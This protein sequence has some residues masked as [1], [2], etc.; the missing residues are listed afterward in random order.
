MAKLPRILRRLA[1]STRNALELAKVGRLGPTYGAPYEIVDQGPHHRL[2]R[3]ATCQDEAGPPVLLVPPLM[4]TSEVYD[5]DQ[6]VS[7][8]AALGRAGLV[9]FVVDFGA[10]ERE[11]GG[12]ERTLDDHVRAVVRSVARVRAITGRD[13][14]L[15][16]YSQG[17]MF[18][19]QAAAYLRSEGIKSLVTFGSPVDIH[20]NVPAVHAEVAGKI[21]RFVEPA[22]TAVV[23]Q[24]EALPGALT[25][26]GFKLLSTR[27]EIEQR[28]EF[29]QKLHDRRALVRRE[30]RRRFLGGEGFVAWPG[31]ALRTFVDE[32]IVHN[33]MLS[34]GF[35]ID[36]RTVTLADI[37]CPI[38]AFM[39]SS[40]ELAR[41]AAVRAITRAAPEAQVSFATVK[42]GHFGIVVGS[43]AS[44]VTWPTVAAWCLHH[45][46]RGPLPELLRS[47]EHAARSDDHDDEPEGAGFDVDVNVELFVDAI[48]DSVKAAWQRLGDVTA[49]AGDALDGVRFQEPR[50]R[51]LSRM[52]P[53]TLVNAGKW[54][55]TRAREAPEA[56][57]FLWQGRA[58]TNR[59]ADQ[60]V[61]NVVRGLWASRVEPRERVGVIMGSRP[62]F[63]T[64]VTALVRLGAV[65]VIA[66][67]DASAAS[68]AR[69]F[70]LE[71]IRVV[72]CDPA[73]AASVRSWFDGE[74]LVL[75]GGGGARDLGPGLVDLEAI[76]PSLVELP[77]ELVLDGGCARDLGLVLLRPSETGELR[78]APVTHHRWA[79]SALGAAAACTLTPDD[80]V[81]CCIPLHHPAGILVSVGAALVGGA[82]LALGS[83]FSV[84]S[85]HAEV[86]RYGASVVFYAGEMLRPLLHERPGRGDRALPV[87][88]FAGSGM[89]TDL[90]ERL[91][92]RF[93]AGI[94]EF[95]AS[96]SQR[97]I[98][99][100]A[101][102]EKP[103]AL[104]RILPGSTE[105]AVVKCDLASGTLLRDLDGHLVR[106]LPGDAGLLAARLDVH[107]ES[108]FDS[109]SH[110]FVGAFG[111]RDRWY[112][113]RDVVRQDRD[114]DHWFVDALS[115]FVATRGGPVSTRAVEEA[116][117]GL[118][119]VEGA[120]AWAESRGSEQVIAAAVS[121]CELVSAERLSRALAQLEPHAR[122]VRI[123]QVEAIALTEGFR[124]KRAE[125]ARLAAASVRS[126]VLD[127]KTG[128]YEKSA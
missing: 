35:V 77:R 34:G 1:A 67:P 113:S 42:A 89:R 55:A 22:V 17:G 80:T 106:A 122:P 27:K 60:R 92:E 20:K 79:L 6:D 29:V 24:L 119:E 44:T 9:P 108:A 71:G 88:L 76:D 98:L 61:T 5:I 75:G 128:S 116:L 107:E 78:A 95:Y 12:L 104:G 102:G 87:R 23:D 46:G 73:N 10:P 26:T 16:G 99:A 81:Y 43:R 45:E 32:F 93:G 33:R 13:A 96:T 47:P 57:F 90:A 64:M 103:S 84:K 123:A 40:D 83:P 11:S 62:S 21:V 4:V 91:R 65:P 54:L 100:N 37:T 94:M 58:F 15:A 48:A 120:V 7:A 110:V 2:R 72:T 70:E 49:S 53:D 109:H 105:I 82:R 14:H 38:L 18:A 19:Y 74:V 63:L 30:A 97:V 124:P 115:G 101:S 68:L 117:Y 127:A 39:G 51:E 111:E 31:P 69:T 118:P 59:E 114:G 8:V 36:G 121:S 85:F 25:S 52:T 66:P 3:Y 125:A 86:R 50:L 28:I 112:V 56:T 41:P 126:F